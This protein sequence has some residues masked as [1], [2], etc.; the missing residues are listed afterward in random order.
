MVPHFLMLFNPTHDLSWIWSGYYCEEWYGVCAQMRTF[1]LMH[2]RHI[3]VHISKLVHV[4][5]MIK[6]TLC[7]FVPNF[8][9]ISFILRMS[10]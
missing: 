4:K 7:N 6:G 3:L 10:S 9:K 1:T 5:E 8:I 2:T